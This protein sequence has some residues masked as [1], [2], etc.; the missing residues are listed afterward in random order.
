MSGTVRS[1]VDSGVVDVAVVGAGFAGL[2]LLHRLRGLGL[3]ARCFETAPDVGGT[4]YWNRYPGARCDVRSVDYSYSFDEGLQQDWDWSERYS[5][6]PEVLSY[7]RHVAERFDLRRSI[8][9]R[10]RIVAAHYDEESA[11]WTLHG[12]DGERARARFCVMATGCLSV[13]KRPEI[14]GLGSFV[15]AVYHSA[16]WPEMG[17]DLAGRRV[18]VFGTGASGVQ[19]IP[20]LAEQASRLTVFQRTPAFSLPAR[21]HRLEPEELA[22]VKRDYAERR[23]VARTTPSGMDLDSNPA[24]ALEVGP[25]RRR[26]EFARR[27]EIGGFSLLGAYADL[28]SDERANGAVAEFVR[29]RIRETVK[30]PDVAERLCPTQYP[31]GTK[32][33]CVDTGYYDTFNRD[34]VRLVDLRETP[35]EAVTTTGVRTTAEH[36]DLDCLV[37]AT[38]F[39]AMTGALGRIDVRGRGGEPLAARWAAGPRTYLGLATAGFPNLFLITGPGSPSVLTNMVASIEQHVEWTTDCIAHVL[40]R[41]G[42]SVEATERAQDEWVAHADAVAARTLYPRAD[43]WYTGAN[44]P[45]KPRR[46]LPYAGGLADYAQTCAAVAADGYRGFRLA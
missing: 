37:L 38:G 7:L 40:A 5:A 24:S 28:L 4:W 27:W 25:A 26:A 8:T 10:T 42:R 15:G 11:T 18:G 12:E 21:N 6:Q 33:P 13:P 1:R 14:P 22:A 17:V 32:R 29:E 36:H 43:S 20:L 30:D 45:G 46:F 41:G 3:S 2:Y 9:F 19:M 34:N 39:D 35:V 44:V 16:R 31:F 23:R